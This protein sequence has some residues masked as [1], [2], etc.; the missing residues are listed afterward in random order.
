[1]RD[2]LKSVLALWHSFGTRRSVI[3]PT[4]NRNALNPANA[5][6]NYL[7]SLLFDETRLGLLRAGFDPMVGVAHADNQYRDSFVYDVM[8]PLRPDMDA[9][10]LEFVQNHTFSPQDFCENRDG[11]IRLRLKLIP[12]LA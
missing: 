7:Y 5:I 11:G 6:L 9:W 8:E 1:L 10:L 4:T 3:N 12:V 2:G